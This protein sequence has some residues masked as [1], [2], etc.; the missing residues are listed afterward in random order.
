MTDLRKSGTCYLQSTVSDYN[1]KKSGLI[2]NIEAVFNNLKQPIVTFNS[3]LSD[4]V[5]QQFVNAMT[6]TNNAAS[7]LKKMKFIISVIDQNKHHSGLEHMLMVVGAK[8]V[9]KQQHAV[10]VQVSRHLNDEESDLLTSA[11]YSCQ[12]SSQRNMKLL[13]QVAGKLNFA[14]SK[15]AIGS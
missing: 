10:G 5:S 6:Q 8:P 13:Q 14:R 12:S 9:Q 7:R 11:L 1:S 3:P 15:Q 4:R 2:E